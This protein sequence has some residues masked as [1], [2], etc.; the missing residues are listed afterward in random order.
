MTTQREILRDAVH[1]RYAAGDP[2]DADDAGTP[3]TGI[4][5]AGVVRTY[6]RDGNERQ[7]TIRYLGV[8]EL[9][10]AANLL[11]R[12][13]PP[14]ECLSEVQ[15]VRLMPDPVREIM[16]EDAAV[17]IAVAQIV[18]DNHAAALEE[19]ALASFCNVRARVAHQ[20]LL[21]AHVEGPILDLTQRDLAMTM[22]SVREVVG[23]TMQEFER[24]GAVRRRADGSMELDLD[25]LEEI[26]AET[27]RRARSS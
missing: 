1:E 8:G 18:L 20:L 21:R 10:G 9:V 3:V 15:L 12:P 25:A 5:T 11:G 6:L 2:L 14:A 23:R 16:R 7:Q 26:Q 19:L 17:A 22:G 4:V 13:I 27:G 24:I